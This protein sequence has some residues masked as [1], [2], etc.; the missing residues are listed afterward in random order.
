MQCPVCSRQAQNLT[1]ATLDGVVVGCDHCGGY[2][3][4]GGAYHGLMR[5]QLEKRMAAL[6]TAKV[7]SRYGWP[8]IDG[9][10]MRV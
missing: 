5:L 6:E 1:P 9:S 4:S 10:C 7:A 2:R 3:I 8:I